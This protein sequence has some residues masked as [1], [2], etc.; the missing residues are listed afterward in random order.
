MIKSIKR[1]LTKN[2]KPNQPKSTTIDLDSVV[3]MISIRRD[4]NSPFDKQNDSQRIIN[5]FFIVGPSP[6]NENNPA[7]LFAYPSHRFCFSGDDFKKI[8]KF[9]YPEGYSSLHGSAHKRQY[10][11]S[12]NEDGCYSYCVC[13]RFKCSINNILSLEYPICLV[14]VTST[15][16]IDSHMK[17]H[18]FLNKILQ[19]HETNFNVNQPGL[20]E[21]DLLSSEFYGMDDRIAFLNN[22]YD[23]NYYMFLKD[24]NPLFA[25]F[26]NKFPKD[27]FSAV[28][29]IFRIPFKNDEFVLKTSR[30][31]SITITKESQQLFEIGR[32]SFPTLFSCLSVHDVV[33]FYRSVLLEKPVLLISDNVSH[34]SDC[35][36]AAIP[37]MLPMSMQSLSFPIMPNDPDTLAFIDQPTPFVMGVIKSDLLDSM[38]ISS[39]IT[40]ID[41]INGT[42]DYPDDICHVPNIDS[43]KEQLKKIKDYAESADQITNIF[44]SFNELFVSE[45][46]LNNCRARD[47]TTPDKIVVVFVKDAYLMNVPDNEIEFYSQLIET[48]TFQSYCESTYSEGT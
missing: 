16:L 39:D 21:S 25:V 24:E 47:T 31:H 22:Y 33:R 19:G 6:Q 13:T 35:A 28:E 17:L 5:Y 1:K 8:L 26:S 9:C 41:L 40:V 42:V 30:H 12:L 36:L 14:S 32:V 27:L 44:Q 29:L 4:V 48:T 45:E 38:E 18:L 20:L 43:L 10:V 15:Y 7:L 2:R 3:K 34:L 11:F 23:K 37:F 46:R